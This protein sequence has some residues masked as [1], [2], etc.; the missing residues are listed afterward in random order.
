MASTN[1]Y[2]R[3]A[4]VLGIQEKAEAKRLENAYRDIAGRLWASLNAWLELEQGNRGLPTAY[5]LGA[6][7]HIGLPLSQAL[8]R[9]ADRRGLQR[10]FARSGLSPGESIAV[11]E[12]LQIVGAWL[13]DPNGGASANLR[14]LWARGDRA[15]RDRLAEVALVE[16]E[17]WSGQTGSLDPGDASGTSGPARLISIVRTFLRRRLELGLE[18]RP[19]RGADLSQVSIGAGGASGPPREVMAIGAGWFRLQDVDG[20]PSSALLTAPLTISADGLPIAMHRPRAVVVFA[21]DDATGAFVERERVVLGADLLVLS[22]DRVT[23]DVL[24]AVHPVARPGYQILTPD[25]LSGIPAGWSAFV[26]LQL[27]AS[28]GTFD[29]ARFSRDLNPL[30]PVALSQLVLGEGVAIPGYIRRW[31][32]IAPPEIRATSGVEGVLTVSIHPVGSDDAVIAQVAPDGRAVIVP[33]V[34]RGLADGDYEVRITRELDHVVGR[35]WLRLRSS[36]RGEVAVSRPSLARLAEDSSWPLRATVGEE[37]DD[38]SLEDGP[39][40]VAAPPFGKREAPAW[41]TGPRFLPLDQPDEVTLAFSAAECVLSG[42]H[43][44]D[45]EE[46]GARTGASALVTGRCRRCGLVRRYPAT[47]SAINA[48]RREELHRQAERAVATLQP[49]PAFSPLPA[50]EAELGERS[51]AALDVLFYLGSG[52][53]TEFEM[54]ASQVEPSALFQYRLLVGLEA[55]GHLD[56]ARDDLL[57]PTHWESRS[58][59]F[60]E[61]TTG[62]YLLVGAI[63]RHA[64]T[65]IANS[66]SAAGGSFRSDVGDLGLPRWSVANLEANA[67]ERALGGVTGPRG[68]GISVRRRASARLAGRLPRLSEVLRGLPTRRPQPHRSIRRF[69]VATGRWVAAPSLNSAGGF[70][71]EGYRVSYAFRLPDTPSDLAVSADSRLVRHAAALIAGEPLIAYDPDNRVLEVPLGAD[72]PGLYGRAAIWASGWL[73]V[74]SRDRPS[75][76]YREIPVD[77]AQA[78]ISKLEA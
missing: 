3:L 34:G 57:S 41:L 2:G 9:A 6:N 65:S 54:L 62:E 64:R 61:L 35:R 68:E 63:G 38:V 18:F 42:A 26:G 17:A 29:E 49:L 51:A 15:M 30:L 21:R 13:S 67:L 72:L 59:C 50:S 22:V 78:L 20:L 37:D 74:R 69:D 56:V 66:V 71:L 52:K 7:R 75:S 33:L 23:R 77:V 73:P 55:L 8:I 14:T 31:S 16:L 45:V 47:W 46:A 43:F 10:L 53:R 48:Q 39:T 76:G 60:L 36:D 58:P 44:L 4:Q 27:M 32:T 1:Y 12:M 11:E 70:R 5:S 28:P 19:G 24:A 25:E 40:I